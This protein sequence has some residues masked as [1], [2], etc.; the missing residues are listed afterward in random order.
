MREARS[1]VLAVSVFQ[2]LEAGIQDFFDAVESGTP[3]VAH[4]V[5]ALVD[6]VQPGVDCVETGVDVA[7]AGVDVAWKE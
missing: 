2:V 6:G 4:V 7:E 3:E 5:E 1:S